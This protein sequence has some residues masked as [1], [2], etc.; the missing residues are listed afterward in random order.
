[1]HLRLS[2]FLDVGI[3]EGNMVEAIFTSCVVVLIGLGILLWI[4]TVASS[5]ANEKNQQ[6]LI[7]RGWDV[8]EWFNGTRMEC[9]TVC[10]KG[11][12][13]F[14][15]TMYWYGGDTF[16]RAPITKAV[17]YEL[18]HAG[19]FAEVERLTKEARRLIDEAKRIKRRHQYR[20]VGTGI[21]PIDN[22]EYQRIIDQV[23]AIERKIQGLIRFKR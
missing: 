21:K 11:S 19:N 22:R 16:P 2:G 9:G 5:K 20:V 13:R 15:Q 1:L 6:W 14:S 23:R 7:D 17:E 3:D 8:N 12:V 18:A 4:L 10:T